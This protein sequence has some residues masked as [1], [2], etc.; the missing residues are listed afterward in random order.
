M[1]SRIYAAGVRATAIS[2]ITSDIASMITTGDDG[3]KVLDMAALVGYL[4]DEFHALSADAAVDA[5]F[6]VAQAAYAVDKVSLAESLN[7]TIRK[8]HWTSRSD[9]PQLGAVLD[10]AAAA[11][12]VKTLKAE[13]N[14]LAQ[15][16]TDHYSWVG[17]ADDASLVN[18]VRIFSDQKGV[19]DDVAAGVVR[20][21]ETRSVI[22]TYVTD[23][24]EESAPSEPADL[25]ELDQND[26]ATYTAPA[27]PSDRN[28]D[29]VRWYRSN[30][31]NS[32]AAFQFVTEKTVAA[33]LTYLDAKKAAE[34]Q[35][36]CPTLTWTE[37]RE[38]LVGLA[39]GPNGMMA[40]GFGNTFALCEPYT[41]YAWPREYEISL[42]YPFVGC[43]A[44]DQGW[45]I[46][47][48]GN[49]Y[50]ATGADPASTTARKLESNQ[51]LVSMRSL[52]KVPGGVLFA[53]PDGYCLATT[54]GV[55]NLT[56][57]DGFNLFTRKQWQALAPSTI[58]GAEHENA[59]YFWTNAGAVC[60]S[61]NLITGKLV[62]V[63]RA[64]SAVYRDLLTDRLYVTSGTTIQELFSAA[65]RRT[66]TWKGKRAVAAAFTNLGWIQAESD[67]AS[68]VSARLYREGTLTDTRSL[69]SNEAARL[70]SQ[71]SKEHEME[72]VAAVD[73]T[74]L[75]ATSDA[76]DLRAV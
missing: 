9:F 10:T 57:E 11:A 21:I 38:N 20:Q 30:S 71:M 17:T 49:P 4:Q 67:F 36:P 52:V 70:T 3:A 42:E 61:L 41:Y 18:A 65:T 47:T 33:G 66:A 64:A 23:L 56:G 28:I 8:E 53:S 55:K 54:S 26:T 35:E 50:I 13:L 34:L 31:S 24:D 6:Y 43:M 74:A 1:T 5:M 63:E 14:A 72:V 15:A 75:I 68:A 32:G 44:F 22:C 76:G 51:A 27:P 39:G 73:V 29:R 58:F 45:F 7:A 46:G 16:V 19:M 25:V 37:P 59:L 12:T 69:T 48:R 62:T 60:Y 40:G 2:N